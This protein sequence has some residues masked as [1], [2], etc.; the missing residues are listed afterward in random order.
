VATQL[1]TY[2]QPSLDP[3]ILAA[4]EKYVADKKAAMP[5]AFV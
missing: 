1:S 5:D 4:L 2:Q 3:E